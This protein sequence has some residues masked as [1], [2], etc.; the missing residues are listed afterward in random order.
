MSPQ[1]AR[2]KARL[3]DQLR[4]SVRASLPFERTLMRLGRP[5]DAHSSDYNEDGWTPFT[6]GTRW[7]GPD[8]WAWFRLWFRVP[9]SWAKVKVR[10]ALPLG[11]QAMS[12]LDGQP[13]QGLDE[14]HRSITLPAEYADGRSHLLAVEAYAA[15]GTTVVRRPADACTIGE[16]RIEWVD[17]EAEAY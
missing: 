16:C 1:E 10:L 3:Q 13:W 14:N 4:A 6:A 9:T 2:L 15:P 17:V 5:K 12:Y 7:G 8:E 11:G